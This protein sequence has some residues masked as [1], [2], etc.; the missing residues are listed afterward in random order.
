DQVIVYSVKDANGCITGGSATVDK[1]LPL[2]DIT[3][4]VT[5]AP[6]CPGNVADITLT[7]VGGYTPAKYEIISPITVDNGTSPLFAGLA[8]NETYLFRVTDANGC[9]IER[10]YKIEPVTPIAIAGAML[11]DISCNAADGTTNNGSAQF[12][13]TGFSASGNYSVVI[14]PAVAAAQI[15]QVGDVITLT[16]LS[17]NTYTVTVEDN[18]THCSDAAA[19]TITEPD[20]IAFG[21][22][23]TKVFC[24]QD[25]SNITVSGVTG[26][27]GAYTYAVVIDGATAPGAS[28]YTNSPVLSVDTNLT[29]FLWDVYVR[30]ANGCTHKVDVSITHNVEPTIVA[31]AAQCY[32]GSAL[33]V[34]LD[35]LTTVYG[36]SKTYI[37]NGTTLGSSTATFTSPGTYRLGIRDDNGCEAFVNYT[38]EKQ[39]LAT[40]TLTKDLYCAG[41]VN[42]TIDVAITDGV[43]PYTYQM[44]LGGIPSG[45]ATS[46][47]GNF[48]ASVSTAGSYTFVITDSNAAVCSVTTN[49]VVVNTPST[50]LANAVPTAVICNGESNGTIT[51]T[52]SNGVAPYTF[53]LSG[54][55]ANAS[56]NATGIYT[57][58]I[59]GTTYSVVVTDAKGCAS[60]AIP[61]TI[62]EPSVLAAT[63]SVTPFGCNSGNVPQPAV[64]T[65]TATVGTGTAPYT[66]S[67][68]GSTTYT[69]VNTLV[70]ADNG[71]DQV[72]AYSVK[73]AN[74]CIVSGSAT[75]NRYLPLTDITFAVTT[76]PVCPTNVADIALTV[77]GGYVPMA[78]YEII[79]PITVNNGN[80]ALFTGLAPDTYLFK[81]T[82]ANGCS[83]ERNYTIV[84]VTPIAIAGVMLNDIS[85]N[86]ADGTTNNGSAQFTVTGFS[87]TG[88]YS[89]V[90]SPAVA[91]GHVSQTGDV[92]TLTGLSSG[93]YTVTVQDNTTHCSAN[94]SVTI[95]AP[96]PIAFTASGTKV[97]C[98]QDI[99]T[100][101]VSSVV[102]GTGSYTYAVVQ[103]GSA[104]P[105]AS[106]YGT[107]AVM[108]VDTNLTDLSWDVYVKD[109]NGCIHRENV[110]I[111]NNV[112]PTINP[113]APQ[114]YAGSALTVDLD[115]L[116]T[117]YGGVKTYTV[118]GSVIPTS[119]ATF[120]SPGTYR[121]G[122]RD[123]NGCEA[124][125]N[126]TIEKQLLATATL[127]K[128]LYCAGSVNATIDVAITD[129]VAP[130]TYQM[131]LGGIPSG[132]ATS[133]VGNFT[134]SVSTAGS[135]TFVITDSNAA[136]CSVTTNA[137]VVNTPSTPL[138]NAVPTAVICNG[139]S[140]GT[141]TVTASNGV[142]PYTFALSGTGANTSGDATG[143]YTGLIAGTTYSVVV[144]DAK[145]CA[146]A[147]VPVTITEP[148]ALTANA[149]VTPF[150]C[151]LTN[152]AKDAIVTI[153]A[154][155]GTTDYTY[156]FDGGTTFQLSPSFS[157]NTSQTINYV[158]LDANGCKV[159]GQAIVNPYLPPRDMDIIATPIYCTSGNV[160]TVTVN[161]VTGG[162]L[163]YTYE[164]ISPAS[165]VT[166]SS[167]TN[168]FASLTPDTYII[169]VT[170]NNGCSI[171]KP[172]IVKEADKISVTHQII[173]DVYC[174][175][176]STGAV[177]FT[178]S[179]YI[180]SANYTFNLIKGATIVSSF[181][182]N[183]DVI[184]YTGLA[185][186]NYTFTVTDAVS[187]CSAPINFTITEPVAVLSSTSV[188]TNINCNEDNATI[189][190]T[191]NGG[192]APYRYAVAK[193]GDPIPT[194]FGPSNQLVVDT[195]NGADV[196]WIVYVL[197]SN[198]CDANN[199][200]PIQPD[201][202]PTV[203]SAVATQCPSV[204]GTYEI[205]V[206]ATGF[207][208]A[209]L[210]SVDGV[211][212]D[213]NNVIT[214]NAPGTYNVTV[215]DANGCSSAVTP[216]TILEPL[217]L[218]PT[219][220]TSPSCTDGDGIVAVSTTGG[221]GNYVYN[222]D[223]GAFGAT[224]PLT[225]VHSGSHIIG[226]K[227]TTTLCEVF[228]TIDLKPA[229]IITGFALTST[230]VT[231][232]G[233]NDGTI[234]ATMDTPAD[235]IND[236]PKYTYSLDGGT[237]QQDS[238]VF[239]GL[240]A[241]TYTVLVTSE[242]GCTATATIPVIQPNPI[243]VNTVNTVQFVCTTGNTS[244]FATIT[245]D[246]VT[247]ISGGSG[248]YVTYEFIKN[249]TQVQI[250]TSNTYTEFDLSGGTYTV[251][252]YDSNGCM[253][254][255]TTPIAIA[256]YIKLDKID[257]VKTAITCTN[258]E[259]ITATA[260]DASGATIAG[261]EYT[262]TDVSGTITF[263][264]NTTGSFTGLAVGQYIITAL[265]PATGCS[266][267]K[268]HYVNQPNTFDLNIVK[269][270]D[271]VCYG[272]NDGAVTITLID[273]IGNPDE[274][275]KFN[276]TLSLLGAVVRSGTSA[277]A[278]PLSLT[279]LSAGEYTV[280]ATLI[281]SPFCTVPA[282]FTIGQP[283]APLQ[284]AETHDAITCISGNNDGRIVVSATG[285]WAGGYEYKLENSTGTIISD[286]SATSEFPNLTA[287]TYTVSVR[288][289]KG[290]PVSTNVVL[291]I[292]KQI[293]VTAVPDMTIVPCYGATS[294]TITATN[295]TGGQGSNYS[296]TLNI[297]TA[298]G[299]ISSGPQASPSFSGLGAGTYSITVTDGYTCKNTSDEVT[300]TEPTIVTPLLVHSGNATC[301]TQD[302]LTLSVTGGT[303]PYTYSAD[304]SF[305]TG[306][307]TLPASGSDTF[308]VAPGEYKYYVKD[309]NGCVSFVSN[310]IKVPEFPEL[311]IDIDVQNVINCKGETTGVIVATATGGVGNYVYTLLI[312]GTTTIVQGPKTDGIFEDLPA[313]NYAVHVV[314]DDCQK[315][316]AVIPITEPADPMVNTTSSTNVT[317]YGSKDGKIIITT[318]G[319]SGKYTYAISPYL[320][321][322]F[323][324]GIFENLDRGH[325]TV[326]IQDASAGCTELIDF[327]I[328]EP[329]PLYAELIP[330]TMLPEQ[331]KGEKNGSFSIEVAGAT[332][333]YSYSLDVRNGTYTLGAIGQTRFDF[334]NLSGGR[335]I[336]YIKDAKA[337]TYELEILMDDAVVLDPQYVIN[338]DCVNN[339]AANSV[340]I[341]V[342]QSITNPADVDYALDGIA[343]YQ[344]SNIF[345]NVAPGK[346]FVM[347]RHTN[348]CEVPTKEFEIKAI[349]PLTLALTAGQQEMNVISVAAAG[350]SPAY[351]YSFNGEEFTSSNT[352]KIYKSG[353][354]EVIVRDQNGCTATL[355]TTVPYVD[356]CIPNY[357][358][359]NGDGLYDEW[360][361]GCTNIY[362]NLEFS[363]FDRYG[364]EIAKYR[365]G[366]K[367]NGKY[368][369]EELPTG[370][371]WYVLKLNDKKD[372]REFVGHFTLYR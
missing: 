254:T 296:Y 77:T 194:S 107:N 172:I 12:T 75:V 36:G 126:Y 151:D 236:N 64:V 96:N 112:A 60:A 297:I 348:G 119:T 115:A 33:T 322:F 273:N 303:A 171:T 53:A 94:A 214:V 199:A 234:T 47:A 257:V 321:Q 313:G 327:E 133:T 123:D 262:L 323:D 28:A 338:Y 349:A 138:A 10:N 176:G 344:A 41:S 146:S 189:T 357:F 97:F 294:A 9:S 342:D 35:A 117:V 4:A 143:V 99:S 307:V 309:A 161:T 121:L 346:H 325:Y 300:I 250:G 8:A 101:T 304:S 168:S 219:V 196:N 220:T 284:I 2:T 265:N 139:E 91:A 164:I 118:N 58:L 295:V 292:P 211:S 181:T 183:G 173:N 129:G 281:D 87:A 245:V 45:L 182:Q 328:T 289:T 320:N 218:T 227:D 43:A 299:V 354:Y 263:T 223:G 200:Q 178:V 44:Y 361:P 276:Y 209:L 311:D 324:D 73:D 141:I 246:P 180:T 50:P 184:S 137:V 366:Q 174:K 37:V 356:V 202:N 350:G 92:I 120:T 49:A 114:C 197:D 355:I 240:T 363:I 68:N 14:S 362:N 264:P 244:N 42:A 336:V 52:A 235:G 190:V 317:C 111:T 104:A 330:N 56:G 5:T 251:S 315:D 217:V 63:S 204:T 358:T 192:T 225:G 95:T 188:A 16:G 175:G 195:K 230:P 341:T 326:L 155:G 85:C 288:D 228:V 314:S 124:F 160:A 274:A 187:G 269:D 271:I 233:G 38:I 270:S 26:G 116:T 59:A 109:A 252:V 110:M 367:W 134:A 89:V 347:A 339:A 331:C 65:V 186:G 67:F 213:A 332:G 290:C 335:H 148:A 201:V 31:P 272:S 248:T 302:S 333:P 318:T 147:A 106:A 293:T 162:A 158:V 105:V 305:T 177:D 55:G 353:D 255:Y 18:T 15:S 352:Y 23:G 359:P 351:M 259:S 372:D 142:A 130:Y 19:V 360:G 69:S 84:P 24:S 185:E 17:A 30:D 66:Y 20:P 34:D 159:T 260:V 221:S 215:K 125:V 249:G 157:V 140:N 61:V 25:I 203:V 231:C 298:T 82:D 286:W 149:V 108:S 136:V 46:T 128:D 70:V 306:V 285:G 256:P 334:D 135:Y 72:I 98:S 212:F 283:D 277:T 83:I 29:D 40:A 79:S 205:T 54:T 343:P 103:G 11:T 337:C 198:N 247:G 78:K 267:Q 62:T 3:F 76:A 275:G 238:P 253:G 371:Y 268:A 191:A 312:S 179:N 206:T 207:N 132:L 153:T 57:G 261:I 222:I 224:T 242:R 266:I 167:G 291:E 279:N 319:G 170:D 365:Y 282:T 122:I 243:V 131:Y 364:R 7:V 340:T 102:G 113:A 345:T 51:V 208:S 154:G 81:V 22:S 301:L 6:V 156:S 71:T 241:G 310:G 93:T 308:N 229:T 280:S 278:G 226:V 232:N 150:G 1:Y 369:G 152:N 239:T 74:G 370:D 169:K 258:L 145:G 368:N 163:P 193:A 13:V 90:T 329:T 21:A 287:E 210:Y 166:A 316:S 216:V 88:N 237:T 39:L 80:N 144:T 86:A 27:T 127:T 32:T 100:I 48:T 165:A